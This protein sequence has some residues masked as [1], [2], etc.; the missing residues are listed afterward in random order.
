MISEKSQ[1]MTLD[2]FKRGR[3]ETLGILKAH[4]YEL[5]L[6]DWLT[7]VNYSKKYGIDSHVVTNWIRRGVIPTDCVVELPVFNNI[8]MI[9]DQAYR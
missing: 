5:D 4:G 8:R 2:E 7:I 9:R 1:T 6:G 3:D